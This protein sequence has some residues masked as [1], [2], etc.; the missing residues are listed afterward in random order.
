MSMNIV[1]SILSLVE[2]NV[3]SRLES[4]NMSGSIDPEF[5]EE[6]TMQEWN[7]MVGAAEQ[8]IKKY[9]SE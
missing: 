2:S 7:R 1:E 4:A 5:A 3:T 8:F 6:V 9:E